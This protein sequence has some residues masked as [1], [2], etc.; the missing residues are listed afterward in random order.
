MKK[1]RS[2]RAELK[3]SQLFPGHLEQ[4]IQAAAASH[5]CHNASA[6]TTSTRAPAIR[7]AGSTGVVSLLRRVSL[8]WR[9]SLLLLLIVHGLLALGLVIAAALLRL[10]T[11]AVALLGITSVRLLLL[12][13]LGVVVVRGAALLAVGTGPLVGRGWAGL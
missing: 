8:L 13:L 12:R 5:G 4:N 7:T 9:V 11:V 1:P 2:R 3:N 6:D 10:G